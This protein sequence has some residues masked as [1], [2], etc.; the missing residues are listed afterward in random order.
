MGIEE[1]VR[2]FVVRERLLQPDGKYI[3][4]LSGGADSVALLRILL[5]LGYCVEAAHCNFHLRGEESDRDEAFVKTLCE[6]REI[7][8]HLIH[9]DTK[10]YAE[11]HHVSIEMAAREL[12][13][14]YFEQLRRD[15]G[16][17]DVC[18]AHHR[19]DS[20]ETILMN[21]IRGT[22]IHGVCGI[23]S[24]NGHIVRPLLCV[25]RADIVAFLHSIGQDYVDD[26][27]NFEDDVV[28]NK[29]RLN[30]VPLLKQINPKA[31]ENI[32]RSAEHLAEVRRVYDS[33]IENVRQRL[34]N[35]GTIDITMLRDEPSPRS[36][37]FEMLNPLGFSPE[38]VGQVF[39]SLDGPTGRRFVSVSH[40]AVIDRGRL[41]VSELQEE[42]RPLV[43]PETG[44][45][46]Y[47]DGSKF[48]V[49]WKEGAAV[50]REPSVATLDADRVQLPLTVRPTQRGDRFVPFG[51]TGSRL[52]SDYL[53]DRKLSFTDK[54]RQLVV[55]DAHGQ[56]VWL[57][58]HRTDNR[59]RVHSSTRRTLVISRLLQQA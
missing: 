14:R 32:V 36:L 58:G 16:A 1:K 33:S 45:Y 57:V 22:G 50:S 10:T 20:V 42:L 31:S 15:I 7:P 28:R 27:T 39:A 34:W 26:S 37:L 2:A 43:I 23:S 29:I 5:K 53:T 24:R 46:V 54:R 51:M 48:R 49:E 11:V 38:T 3:V 55:T 47:G 12:R 41:L 59:C 52:V 4:A 17:E 44:T 30:V 8:L 9:F 6:E 56:I 25:S 40:E 18:V 13:Y 19:D 35:D 21:L